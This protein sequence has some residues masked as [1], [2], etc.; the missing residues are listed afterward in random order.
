MVTLANRVKVATATTGTGIITLGQRRTV[1]KPSL[2]A[3][4]LM[5]TL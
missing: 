2:A 1:I 3:V 4:Y 5:V